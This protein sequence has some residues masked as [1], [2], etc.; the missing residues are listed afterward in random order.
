M[1]IIKPHTEWPLINNMWHGLHI[2]PS[3]S[4]NSNCAILQYKSD[5]MHGVKIILF[6]E[7]KLI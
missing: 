4:M 6:A 1:R 7:K 2:S 3:N 5:N